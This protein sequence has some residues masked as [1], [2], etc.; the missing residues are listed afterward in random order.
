MNLSRTDNTRA[1]TVIPKDPEK[2][3]DMVMEHIPGAVR[4]ACYVGKHS[5]SRNEVED[6]CQ[7]IIIILIED[8][9]RRLRTFRGNS[10]ARTWVHRVVKRYVGDK[11]RAKN[12]PVSLDDIEPCSLTF[13]PIQEDAVL[14]QE[15]VEAI[16]QVLAQ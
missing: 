5:V 16:Q 9:Y 7:D 4:Y 8:N 12:K 1:S 11:L 14:Y 10:S 2:L 15:R 6:L 13:Q 3:L